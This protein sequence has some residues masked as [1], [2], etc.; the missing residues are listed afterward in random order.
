MWPRKQPPLCLQ[1]DIFIPLL[2]YLFPYLKCSCNVLCQ[3]SKIKVSEQHFHVTDSETQGQEGLKKPKTTQLESLFM[4]WLLLIHWQ[5]NPFLEI[6]IYLIGGGGGKKGRM[7]VLTGGLFF[8]FILNRLLLLS[9]VGDYHN[10]E[11]TSWI[12]EK[13]LGWMALDA[14]QSNWLAIT[15]NLP[16]K[17][18]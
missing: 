2:T 9:V 4:P 16:K 18:V 12:L 17:R 10:W 6:W 13:S 15:A 7:V 14:C 5:V 1:L 11:H 3:L 8:V